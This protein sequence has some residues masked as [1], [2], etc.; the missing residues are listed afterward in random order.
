M[1]LIGPHSALPD[2]TA[3]HKSYWQ[4]TMCRFSG[5]PAVTPLLCRWT[6]SIQA[7]VTLNSAL[8]DL[9]L[10]LM[11]TRGTTVFVMMTDTVS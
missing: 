1:H 7:T 10:S 8:L 4:A 11:R 2:N 6:G 5:A 3:L 9:N